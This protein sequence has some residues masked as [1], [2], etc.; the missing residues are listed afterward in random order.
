MFDKW[1][2][3]FCLWATSFFSGAHPK[4]DTTVLTVPSI[5][6]MCVLE[7][8]IPDVSIFVSDVSNANIN[9]V[10]SKLE[11]KDTEIYFLG[12]KPSDLIA[13]LA[14]LVSAFT[15]WLNIRL[16]TNSYKNSV[17]DEFWMRQIL[18]PK[19]MNPFMKFIDESV[20]FY[21]GDLNVYYRKFALDKLNELQD[22]IIVIEAVSPSLGKELTSIIED[23]HDVVGEENSINSIEDFKEKVL[24]SSTRR[25][26]IAMKNEQLKKHRSLLY[27]LVM[28]FKMKS[29][30]KK[31]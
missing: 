25:A 27:K 7:Y 10:N 31:I 9:Q 29:M 18:I 17:H 2:L 20:G 30:C 3:L 13:I 19:F 4:E 8:K 23:F 1:F 22:S 12:L 5:N 26:V 21:N 16:A 24:L 6:D 28:F 14:L 15:I 11:P